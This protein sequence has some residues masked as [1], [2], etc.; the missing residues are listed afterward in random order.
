MKLKHDAKLMLG[1]TAG[2]AVPLSEANGAL[3]VCEGVENGLSLLSGL[4]T[5]PATVW[6][7]LSAP[8]LRSVNLPEPAGR[9]IIALDNDEA[10]LSATDA[11]AFRAHHLGWEVVMLHPQQGLDWNDIL[12]QRQRS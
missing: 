7:A 4:L 9:L 10:G 1:P 2:G 12:Q 5:E 11:L 6:A 3:V 8:G